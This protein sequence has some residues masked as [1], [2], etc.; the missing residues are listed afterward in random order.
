MFVSTTIMN[1]LQVLAST[2][3]GSIQ[4]AKSV[5]SVPDLAQPEFL[6]T[7]LRTHFA[8]IPDMWGS[9]AREYVLASD[10]PSL[11]DLTASLNYDIQQA[12]PQSEMYTIYQLLLRLSIVVYG[13]EGNMLRSTSASGSPLF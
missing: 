2:I 9:T 13:I 5:A 3:S 4:A 12:P 6:K 7:M 11:E 10:H 8:N 1:D